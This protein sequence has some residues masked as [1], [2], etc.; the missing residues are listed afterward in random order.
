MAMVS[1]C[2]GFVGCMHMVTESIITDPEELVPQM[3]V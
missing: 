2:V 3:Y 1:R